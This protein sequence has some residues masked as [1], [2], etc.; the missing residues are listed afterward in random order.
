MLHI[1][2]RLDVGGEVLHGEVAGHTG[3]VIQ[4]LLPIYIAYL[5][6][7]EDGGYLLVD[8]KN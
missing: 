3:D 1:V 4:Q 6:E 5:R 8:S 7:F 2:K